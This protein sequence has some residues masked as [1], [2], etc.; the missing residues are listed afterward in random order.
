MPVQ[1]NSRKNFIKRDDN[2]VCASSPEIPL[3]QQSEAR[4]KG[5]LLVFICTLMLEGSS[6]SLLRS[7]SQRQDCQPRRMTQ[8]RATSLHV[9]IKAEEACALD[10]MSNSTFCPN[11]QPRWL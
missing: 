5:Y 3:P 10:Q 7:V 9:I 2:T 8:L 4:P 1:E 11:I 6:T